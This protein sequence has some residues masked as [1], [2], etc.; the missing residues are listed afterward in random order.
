MTRISRTLRLAF[1]AGAMLAAPVLAVADPIKVGIVGP[2]TGPAANTGLT[3]QAAWQLVVDR[4]NAEGGIVIDGEM[5]QIELIPADSQS[6]ASVGVSAAQRLL[7]RD[8][9]DIVVGVSYPQ[10][11]H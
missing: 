2:V 7:M 10:T 9:V 4:Y 1:M 3:V 11:G 8:Q 5:R 6:K